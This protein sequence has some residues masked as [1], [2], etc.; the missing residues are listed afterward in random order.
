MRRKPSAVASD[1]E[2]AIRFAWWAA[3]FATLTLVAVLGLA[4]SAQ[5]LTIPP[6]QAPR[7]VAAPALPPTK[8]KKKRKPA[9]TKASKSKN[10]KTTKNA[11]KTK[12]AP[13]RRRSAC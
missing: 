10:A 13:R 12:P 6:P 2:A 8:P 1:E 7:T 4:K 9:K 11:K 3:F 5:A